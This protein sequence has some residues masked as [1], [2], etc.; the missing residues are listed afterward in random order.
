M[1]SSAIGFSVGAI[2]RA[3]DAFAQV[4]R[5]VD[6][7]QKELRALDKTTATATADVDTSRGQKSLAA[8]EAVVDRLDGRRIKVDADID[9][10]NG[11]VKILDKS[12]GAATIRV[13]ALAR[14]MSTIAL[15]GAIVAATPYIASLG[16]SAVQAAGS[17]WLLPAAAVAGGVAF[18][19]LKVGMAGFG[20]AMKNLGDPEKFAESIAKLSPAA[21]DAANAVRGLVPAWT[22]MQQVVQNN[23]FAGVAGSMRELAGNYIP[24][25]QAGLGG[26][27]SAMN[28]MAVETAAFF[29]TSKTIS[30]VAGI[31]DQVKQAMQA[32]H[33]VGASL[34]SIFVDIAAVGATF[35]PGL[36]RGF[37]AAASA[38][39]LFIGNAR[40]TGQLAVW[41]QNGLNTIEQLSAV[42]GNVGSILGSVFAA[43]AAS[44]ES[45]LSVLERVTGTAAAALKTPEGA[46][47]LSA[48]FTQ[49]RELVGL[50][51][52]KLVIMWPAI[53]AAGTAFAALLTA[54]APLASTLLSLVVSALVP[55]LDAVT[56]L[57]PV[58]GPLAVVFLA[59]SAAASVA[60]LAMSAWGIATKAV[61]LG[62]GVLSAILHPVATAT[63]IWA[64]AQWL[65]NAA[66]SANPLALVVIA[67]AALAAGLILAWN[68]SETFRAVVTGAFEAVG[69]AIAAVV[70]FF[71][72]LPAS[73]GGMLTTLGSATSSAP[74]IA[75]ASTPSAKACNAFSSAVSIL[76]CSAASVRQPRARIS[77]ASSAIPTA[78]PPCR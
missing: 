7:L 73:I 17:L 1:A 62:V 44:G 30:S 43:G 2:D 68:H 24:L 14:A 40:E 65:L 39:A 27:A 26:A 6:G 76:P 31:F 55:M 53:Q 56:W 63:K 46:A 35:L 32:L 47:A 71:A 70:D 78:A 9:G 58:L 11:K 41:I 8:F 59:L 12:F 52:D 57:A 21:R 60:S 36:A 15:P 75:S 69:T 29:N 49:I 3:S 23:L 28:R 61:S 18:G 10:V 66:M 22:A 16:A 72:G 51:V 77:T 19:A 50:F 42:L 5:A 20:D 4:A 33:G 13:A 34:S 48:F 74:T 45:F 64:A 38:A 37:A 67:I 25:L 54:A